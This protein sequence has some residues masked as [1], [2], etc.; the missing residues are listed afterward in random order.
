MLEDQ[1]VGYIAPPKR[2]WCVGMGFKTGTILDYDDSTIWPKF[3][4]KCVV[5]CTL[6]ERVLG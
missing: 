6:I 2:P 1:R 5:E 4:E 3:W